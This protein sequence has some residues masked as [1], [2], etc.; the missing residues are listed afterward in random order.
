MATMLV[1]GVPPHHHLLCSRAEWSAP[2]FLPGKAEICK[3]QPHSLGT[4]R[5]QCPLHIPGAPK[6]LLQGRDSKVWDL[7]HN[8]RDT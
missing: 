2:P 4:E 6:Y 3:A 1:E 7:A 5:S 8:T